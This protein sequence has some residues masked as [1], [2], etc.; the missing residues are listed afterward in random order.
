MSQSGEASE[1][2]AGKPA[3]LP[4]QAHLTAASPYDAG[5]RM[6][7]KLAQAAAPDA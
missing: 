3:L 5:A 2:F 7:P 4:L 6:S 1:N